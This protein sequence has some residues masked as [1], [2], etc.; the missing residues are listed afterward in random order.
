M[1]IL[2]VGGT[3][4][5][6][7]AIVAEAASRG[8]KVTALSRTLPSDRVPSVHYEAGLAAERAVPLVAGIDVV[9]G[10]LSAKGTT[11]G[12]LVQT[13]ADLG[14]AAARAGARLVVIGGFGSML[15]AEGGPR[16][17]D[18]LADLDIP[19]PRKAEG[20]EM[21]EVRSQLESS[22]P[23]GLDWLFVCPAAEFG[24]Y[25]PQGPA[26]GVYRTSGQVAL[27]DEEGRSVI[28]TADLARAV[29]DQIEFPSHQR[30]QIH[31]AY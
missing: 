26:R 13:Y 18:T 20:Y 4:Y 22:S 21:E 3:G 1:K 17:I 11:L 2:V 28:E 27:F 19:E 14:D 25:A 10:A 29:L 7:K 8:H 16:A 31:F 30:A 24:P 6:G 23:P 9:V 12:T 5:A 15:L